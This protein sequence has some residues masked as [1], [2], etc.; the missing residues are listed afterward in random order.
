[1]S[2]DHLSV[3]LVGADAEPAGR[4]GMAELVQQDREQKADGA[5]DRSIDADR[6]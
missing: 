5:G 6:T 2:A 4:Q 1:M 3:A